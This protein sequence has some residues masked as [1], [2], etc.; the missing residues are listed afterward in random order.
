MTTDGPTHV[1][2]VYD[3]GFYTLYISGERVGSWRHGDSPSTTV[4]FRGNLSQA[5]FD[6]ALGVDEVRRHH[7]ASG[8]GAPTPPVTH[9]LRP[10]EE[11]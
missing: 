10:W 3:A 4:E 8:G 9:E 11:P 5:T 6:R 2:A 1:A 7:D